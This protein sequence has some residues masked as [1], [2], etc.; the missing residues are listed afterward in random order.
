MTFVGRLPSFGSSVSSGPGPQ[1]SCERVDRHGLA[2]SDERRAK[3]GRGGRSSMARFFSLARSS[4][5]KSCRTTW[6]TQHD[7]AALDLAIAHRQALVDAQ[8]NRAGRLTEAAYTLLARYRLRADESDL[9]QTSGLV[10]RA[11]ALVTNQTDRRGDRLEELARTA[12]TRWQQ[13]RDVESLQRSVAHAHAAVR[14]TMASDE[15]Y[16]SRLSLFATCLRTRFNALHDSIDIDKA[17]SLAEEVLERTEANDAER[18]GRLS[19]LAITLRARYHRTY[20]QCDLE[21]SIIFA[22]QALTLT[23][24]AHGDY[25]SRLST[26]SMSLRTRFHAGSNV[27][28]LSRALELAKTALERTQS[29]SAHRAVRLT[30]LGVCHQARYD[31][32]GE[33]VDVETAVQLKEA[34]I[35]EPEDHVPDHT[36]RLANLA[37][38]LRSRYDLTSER[39][40]LERCIELGKAVIEATPNDNPDSAARLTSLAICFFARYALDDN[41]D[42]LEKAAP[43]LRGAV[44]TQPAVHPLR[45]WTQAQ[46]ALVCTAAFGA[47]HLF[48]DLQEAYSAA[49]EAASVAASARDRVFA[50]TQLARTLLTAFRASVYPATSQ[51][52]IEEAIVAAETSLRWAR[53]GDELMQCKTMRDELVAFRQDSSLDL[54]SFTMPVR[55]S[56]FAMFAASDLVHSR[57][58]RTM[59]TAMAR[60][61]RYLLKRLTNLLPYLLLRCPMGRHETS[62]TRSRQTPPTL[63]RASA[64]PPRSYLLKLNMSRF[65]WATPFKSQYRQKESEVA[66]ML[67]YHIDDLMNVLTVSGAITRSAFADVVDESPMKRTRFLLSYISDWSND[68]RLRRAWMDALHGLTP[69]CDFLLL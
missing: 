26:L 28:D 3:T 31:C 14:R 6:T 53:A 55:R 11:L 47:R 51:N 40:D 64:L 19:M 10:E 27:H 29:G 12:R 38:S 48:C 34:A 16:L 66:M 60:S 56:L 63:R 32:F 1:T 39:A 42:D 41:A 2:Y 49:R 43:L 46:L 25:P 45:A 68:E 65:G 33:R 13:T 50:L 59:A 15:R 7:R 62:S 44:K 8:P 21:R 58:P 20:R 5:L 36:R 22:E 23:D 37:V 54:P 9:Q 18:A 52:L 67:R 61:L 4:P 35:K 17:I 57:P 30:S 69:A 24:M